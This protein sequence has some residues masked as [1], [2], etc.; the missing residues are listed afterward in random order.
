MQHNEA[1]K[2]IDNS[3]IMDTS[4][5]IQKPLS[6]LLSFITNELAHIQKEI[7]QK[8]SLDSSRTT[9]TI[10]PPCEKNPLP[11]GLEVLEFDNKSKEINFAT[12]SCDLKTLD[13]IDKRLHDIP[14]SCSK[15]MCSN[16]KGNSINVFKS[17]HEIIEDG[18]VID[19]N[20]QCRLEFSKELCFNSQPSA[21]STQENH[22]E[23][24]G[25]GT[26]D[27]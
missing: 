26:L 6:S 7:S 16:C 15:I 21:P 4:L 14:F 5:Q 1:N 24:G 25:E 19:R 20:M 23:G 17:H 2:N 10:S 3:S 27:D 9:T 18:R 12:Q 11:I 22:K 13:A 8:N